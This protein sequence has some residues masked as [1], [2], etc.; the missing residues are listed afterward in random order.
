MADCPNQLPLCHCSSPPKKHHDPKPYHPDPKPSRP[1]RPAKTSSGIGRLCIALVA[2][3]V[4]LG[5]V[6]LILYLVYRPTHARFSVTS[7]AILS[8]SN[9]SSPF[10]CVSTSAQVTIL[11]RNP[12]KHSSINYDCLSV[13]LSYRNQ[14][15]TY[16]T[17]LPALTQK[18]RSSLALSPVVGGGAAIPVSYDVMEGLMTDETYGLIGL[19][20]VVQGRIKFQ[21]GPFYGRWVPLYVRCDML[22]GARK[23]FMGQVPVLGNPNCYVDP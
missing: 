6:A 19:R 16:S 12:N 7:F 20:L 23:E 22:I 13:F 14:A 1:Y 8:L 18:P 9:S 2:F 4:L 17:Q 5:I 11:I 3:F 15:I 21:S 10:T